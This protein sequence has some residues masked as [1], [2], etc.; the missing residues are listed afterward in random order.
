[1]SMLTHGLQVCRLLCLLCLL[2]FAAAAFAADIRYFVPPA[3]AVK[4]DG[5]LDDWGKI[6]TLVTIDQDHLDGGWLDSKF[7]GLQDCQGRLRMA[8]DGKYL[9]LALA[10]TDNSVVP[11]T[12]KQAQP[13]RFWLQDG[14][15]FYLDTPGLNLLSGR[16]DTKPTRS[17]QQEPI[18]QLTP[19]TDNFGLDVLP[20]SSRYA[21]IIGKDGYVV[22]AAIPWLAIGWQ[23]TAGDRMFFGAILVDYDQTAD[24]KPGPLRQIIWHMP[25]DVVRPQSRTWAE[26]RLMTAGGFGS[27]LL[28]APPVV[29]QGEPLAWRAQ[30]DASQSGWRITNIA[31]VKGKSSVSLLKAPMT[32]DPAIRTQVDGTFSTAKLAPGVYTLETTAVKGNQTEKVRQQV[33]IVDGTPSPQATAKNGVPQKFAVGDP[34]RCYSS[35]EGVPW[36]QT[37]ANHA[38]YLAFVK[39]EM[40][41]SW[42]TCEYMLRNRITNVG[43]GW[44]QEFTLRTAA[45]AKVTKDPVWIGRAQQMFEMA[46]TAY[47]ANNY[48]GMNWINM[49]LLYYTKQY[50]SAVNAWKPEYEAMAKDWFRH[51]PPDYP[52]NPKSVFYGMNNWGLACGIQGVMFQYWL[53]EEMPDKAQWA[54][55][56][57]DTW[58]EFFEKVKDIDENTTNYASWDM[59]MVLLYLDIH[60]QTDLLKTDPKLRYFFERYLYEIAPSGARP[61]YGATNGWHDGLALW[62]YL[63]ERVGQVTGDGR[64]KYQARQIWDYS[65]RHVVDWHNYHM[66][67]DQTL[68]MLVRLLAELPD[69]TLPAKPIEAKSILTTRGAMRFTTTAER[70]QKNLAVETSA[71]AVP[72]KLIFRGSNDPRSL[73]AMVEL[74]NDAGHCTARPTSINTLMDR[75]TVLL[76]S[77]GYNEN[78]ASF[79]NMVWVED[80]EGTQGIQPEMKITVP[81]MKDSPLATYAVA[82]VERYMRWPVTLRRHYFFAKD[83]FLWVRDEVRFNST[84]F[85]RVG[86]C[87]LTRQIGPVSGNNWVNSYF[88]MI[89]Y[90][91]LGQGGVDCRWKNGN[92]DLL[93]YCVPRPGAAL[94][95]ADLTPQ[96]PFMPA[97][98]QIR[99]TWTGLA[100]Q[101]QG[102]T[103]DTLLIPHP[104]RPRLSDPSWVADTITPL[105]TDP[106]VTAVQYEMVNHANPYQTERILVVIGSKPFTGNGVSTDAQAAMVVWQPVV[107][108]GKTTGWKVANWYVYQGTTL[109]VGDQVLF[110]SAV[111]ADK[112]Q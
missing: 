106:Q 100:K 96:N 28:T 30:A 109:K 58:G 86:P 84:F 18:I 85:A 15:G 110:Q 55:L 73:W 83:R 93:T 68:T 94:T 31:L 90:T 63:F 53:G 54:K 42:P 41:K 25:Q 76:S 92:Y 45:Y 91:G 89:P 51:Y 48:Q 12:T 44:Y 26:A 46:D 36:H 8:Y 34:M 7:N 2:L 3:P 97:P 78:D 61:H 56:V 1:M 21:C 4:I 101:G 74:N 82:E 70:E 65:T 10:V 50:L 87:W 59:W 40:E 72:N 35:A 29:L 13:Y 33:T 77:Q 6:G 64:Y 105:S 69:D 17:W 11:I 39:Q 32:V 52:K 95:F 47:K 79:H 23:P 66:V 16:Y 60:G 24:G 88:D 75:E 5:N 108:N 111:K 112:E 102:L 80:L 81:V 19:S 103:F 27:E 37:T 71:E 43:G 57:Q 67:Y 22:E 49:P 20:A 14:V 107:E 98:L 38:E 9:Y 104:V 99:Q 62:M